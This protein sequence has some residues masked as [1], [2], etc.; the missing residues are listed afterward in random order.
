MTAYCFSNE[1]NAVLSPDFCRKEHDDLDAFVEVSLLNSHIPWIMRS[2]YSLPMDST[3][4]GQYFGSSTGIDS[5]V[6]LSR[7]LTKIQDISRQVEAIRSGEDE[8]HKKSNHRTI[9]HDLLNSGLPPKELEKDRLRDEALGTVTAGSDTTAYVLRGAA[10]H[11]SAN[12]SVNQ[13]LY[14]ELKKAIPDPSQQSFPSLAELEKLPYLSAVV[15][16]SLRLCNPITHRLSRVFPDKALRYQDYV[17]P[18][19]WTVGMTAMLIHE[20]ESI[21][22]E[23]YEFRPERWLNE[24]FESRQLERYCVPFN[25]G[26]RVCL[27]LNLARAELFL[28][29]A[30][31]FRQFKFDV[32]QVSRA[33]DIDLTRDFLIG[34]T[35]ADSP[36]ILVGVERAD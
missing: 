15:Q 26:V 10:Y 22:P 18:P 16:E 14:T 29:L 19:G 35:I 13:K 2:I 31:L 11:V 7:M 32:S 27:G 33:R 20:N 5:E 30:V 1:P 8:S 6:Y 36:G 4:H 25:K 9:F 21:Y 3:G 17:I 28:I 23:P 24:D 34:A 12:P